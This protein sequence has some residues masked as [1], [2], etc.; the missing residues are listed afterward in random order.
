MKT[1]HLL[2]KLQRKTKGQ[3]SLDYL[4]AATLFTKI[5]PAADVLDPMKKPHKEEEDY[6]TLPGN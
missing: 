2:E 3:Q 1:Q 4:Y 5:W 6:E